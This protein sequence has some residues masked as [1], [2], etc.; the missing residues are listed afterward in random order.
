MKDTKSKER[1]RPHGFGSVYLR[2]GSRVYLMA[3][4][5]R[6]KLVR[7]STG[8][9]TAKR[10][11]EVLDQRLAE[12]RTGT[13]AGLESNIT[14]GDLAQDTMNDQKIQGNK[15]TRGPAA[16]WR[17]HL[18]KVFGHLRAEDVRRPMI[19]AYVNARL[20]S[21]ASNATINRELSF[22]KRAFNLGLERE[23]VNRVPSFPHLTEDNVREGFPS[24]EQFDRL[25][26][27][28]EAEGLWLRAM[29]EVAGTYGWRKG[30]L[31]KMHVR[32]ADLH[33]GTLRQE[34]TI[35]KSK[36]GNEVKMT[37]EIAR[38]IALCVKG[39]TRADYLFTRAA[40]H[41]PISSFRKSWERVTTEAGCPNLLFHDLCRFSARNLDAAG[42]SQSVA[43][44][45]M[46]RRTPSIFQRYDIV[47]QADMDR[48]IDRLSLDH[49][50]VGLDHR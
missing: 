46:G 6:G 7:V 16:S 14:V 24:V 43:M 2:E 33:R 35:T 32:N 48:A 22:L 13:F 36:K 3:Y 30:S 41:I 40:G 25:K 38:L 11:R 4:R 21:G 34:G 49:S 19:D 31:L 9:I 28:C 15:N 23:K 37:P 5:D 1:R 26:A 44:Q 50:S 12:I 18:S 10:A 20:Q 29:L 8:E 42:V 17:L 39:K 45:I 47:G 27:A